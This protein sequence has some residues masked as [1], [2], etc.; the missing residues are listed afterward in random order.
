M[1]SERPLSVTL[2]IPEGLD[3]ADL[4]LAREPDGSVSFDWGVIER[5]AEASGIDA[6]SIT[7]IPEDFVAGLIAGWYNEHRARGGAPDPV[8]EDLMREVAYEDARG[9]GVSHEPG[10]G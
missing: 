2:Q 8:Q 10:R 5:I 3:F 9:G 4:K 1:S 6:E 7:R